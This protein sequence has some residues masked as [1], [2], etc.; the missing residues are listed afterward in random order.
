MLTPFDDSPNLD[1][2]GKMH[3]F[4]LV[5]R[6][7]V[8]QALPSCPFITHCAPPCHPRPRPQ[9]AAYRCSEVLLHHAALSLFTLFLSPG[10][11]PHPVC[12]ADT[13]PKVQCKGCLFLQAFP[14]CVL[15]QPLGELTSSFLGL[16]SLL[17]C[18]DLPVMI[19]FVTMGEGR[20]LISFDVVV[21]YGYYYYA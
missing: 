15:L 13:F 20:N 18:M 14:D 19:L 9:G 8:T 7:I 6:S 17:L 16:F 10:C 11:L 1:F 12:L 21:L 5:T 3:T 2:Q 4:S